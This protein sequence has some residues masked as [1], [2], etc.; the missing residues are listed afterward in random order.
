M[1]PALPPT[2]THVLRD[3]TLIWVEDRDLGL[4][5]QDVR[6]Y[7]FQIASMPVKL[8]VYVAREQLGLFWTA[9]LSKRSLSIYRACVVA[10]GRRLNVA[11]LFWCTGGPLRRLHPPS[12]PGGTCGRPMS[13]TGAPGRRRTNLVTLLPNLGCPSPVC[14]SVHAR[15]TQTWSD[16]SRQTS[17]KTRETSGTYQ[18]MHCNTPSGAG[19]YVVHILIP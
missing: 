5:S 13:G 7:T 19:Y 14:G 3:Y 12:I 15:H 18:L 10:G 2:P 4:I 1:P 16:G 11:L 17:K 6:D 8:R 9:E